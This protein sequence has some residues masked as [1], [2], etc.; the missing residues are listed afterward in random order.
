[1]RKYRHRRL[2][3]I[4]VLTAL[5]LD[6]KIE[7]CEGCWAGGRCVFDSGGPRPYDRE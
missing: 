1:M 6:Y 2:A 4:Q 7:V 3:R 5:F